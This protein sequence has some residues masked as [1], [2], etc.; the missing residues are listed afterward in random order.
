MLFKK[1][2][3]AI[4]HLNF[5]GAETHIFNLRA[6]LCQTYAKQLDQIFQFVWGSHLSA[7]VYSSGPFVSTKQ[8]RL[9]L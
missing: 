8:W 9:L 1:K 6:S 2:K 3:K 4:F 7:W 5:V